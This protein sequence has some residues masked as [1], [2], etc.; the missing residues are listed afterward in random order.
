MKGLL[1]GGCSFTWGQGLY[2]YSDLPKLHNPKKYN[3][4]AHLVTQAQRRFKD[5]IRYPRLVANHF[6]TFESFKKQ[7]GGSEDETFMFFKKIFTPPNNHNEHL[8]DESHDYDDFSYIII[9]LSQ[10]FRNRFYFSIDGK[11]FSCNVHPQAG[12][13]DK[14]NLLKW[15]DIN[16]FSLNDWKDQ[17]IEQQYT[18]LLAELKFYEDKGIKTKILTWE[19]DLLGKIKVDEYL[20]SRFIQLNYNGE[21]FDTIN[22]LQRRHTKMFIEHD[23]YFNGFVYNDHHPSKLCHQVIAENIINNIQK[24]LK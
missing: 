12:W 10:I 14:D 5:T 1:F 20:K 15:M 21:V 6:N 19:D 22:Q 17:L 3:Y 2:F 24:D 16:N 7:N 23:P 13:G 11:Q 18:R 8:T 9:Q 4:D